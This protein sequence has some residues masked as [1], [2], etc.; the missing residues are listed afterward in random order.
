MRIGGII[1]QQIC[2]LRWYL[3]ACLGLI[4]VLPIEEAVVNF[5]AGVGFYSLP[6]AAA[7][8]MF[9]PLLAGLIACANVQGDLDEKRYIFWRSKPANVKLLM[10]V[11]FF[12]GLIASFIVLVCPVVFAIATLT[13]FA[14]ERVEREP[15]YSVPFFI[16]IGIM[17]Y[18][19]CFVCNVLVRR[20]ARAWLIGMLLAGL[21]LV[22]PFVLPLNLRDF[23]TDIMRYTLS[24]YLV[25]ILGASAAA[26]VFSLYATEHDWHLRTNLK[27]LLWVGLGLLFILMMLFSSQVANIKVLDEKE[28]ESSWG[29][30][31]LES[32]GNRVIFKGRSYVDIGKEGISL[33]PIGSSS[34]SEKRAIAV[35]SNIG[36]DSAGLSSIYGRGMKGLRQRSYPIWGWDQGLHRS[37]GN[38]LYDFSILMYYRTEKEGGHAKEVYEKVYLRSYKLTEASWMPVGEIDISDC[39]TDKTSIF[40][41]AMRLIDDVLVV[42]VNQSCVAVDVTV[43]GELKQID[44]KLDVLNKPMPYFPDREKE[45]TIPLLPID[46]IGNNERIKLSIDLNYQFNYYIRNKV[47]KSSMVD[48]HDGRISFFLVSQDSIARF[49]VTRWDEKK[50]YCKFASARPFTILESIGGLFFDETFVKGGNL[51]CC[52]KGTLLVFDIR[53]DRKIRKLGHFVRMDYSIEDI[54]VLDDGDI[55]LCLRWDRNLSRSDPAKP[56]QDYLCLLENPS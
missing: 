53:S 4:M 17:T 15:M 29:K 9:S 32:L 10:T 18:S 46:S 34:G 12:V 2:Q 11:K 28:I 49:D 55:L 20:S 27:G 43:P 47:Y 30:R 14:K 54:E 31:T 41:M 7:A 45:F 1:H 23:V 26:F 40:R 35:H 24:Y 33:R 44:T 6:L 51:Y 16:L 56:E 52:G 19:L 37:I 50:I 22:L 36:I 13:L 25:I 48:I 38:D 8:V 21:L 42:C 3:L 5:R 39:L